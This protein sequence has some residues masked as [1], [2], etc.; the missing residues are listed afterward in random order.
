MIR[1][2]YDSPV[3]LGDLEHELARTERRHHDTQAV[4]R[5]TRMTDDG[6]LVVD[7]TPHRLLPR[8]LDQLAAKLRVPASYLSRCPTDL[9]AT[10]VNRW[11]EGSDAELLV[12]FDGDTVRALLSTRYRPVSHLEVVR[13]LM[14]SVPEDTPVRYELQAN[15]F[16]AQVLTP[17][18]MSLGL[19]GGINVLNSE[20]GHAAVQ[21]SAMVFRTICLNGLILGGQDVTLRRRHTHD[22]ARTLEELTGTARMAWSH[23]ADYPDRFERTRLVRI[24]DPEPVFDRIAAHH[25]LDKRQREALSL[26]F[27]IEPGGT[28]FEVINAVTRAANRPQLE[29]EERV[30]LQELGGRMVALAEA[31][32]RW[33]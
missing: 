27:R 7:G 30:Q 6:R 32:H 16:M 24:P 3:V 25:G 22:A 2:L 9:A 12:R 1:R 4:A 5:S 21:L 29:L 26:A 15:L 23:A 31:G 28:L 33:L 19:H 14:Q 10:N 17:G 18:H 13:G 20:T 8:A 11:L